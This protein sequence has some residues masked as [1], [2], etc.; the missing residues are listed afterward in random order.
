MAAEAPAA[1][2][3]ASGVWAAIWEEGVWASSGGGGDPAELV[4]DLAGELMRRRQ[5]ARRGLM[6][7]LR[8][9]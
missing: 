2:V 7:L 1:P 3:W 4:P 6:V 9:R 5:G 8:G